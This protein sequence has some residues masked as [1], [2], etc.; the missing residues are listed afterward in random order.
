MSKI[1]KGTDRQTGE[2]R[3]CISTVGQQVTFYTCTTGA[4]IDYTPPPP[5]AFLFSRK[6]SS[7]KRLFCTN[8]VRKKLIKYEKHRGGNNLTKKHQHRREP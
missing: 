5:Q 1:G 3:Y 2:L 8:A 6:E 4:Q 7:L